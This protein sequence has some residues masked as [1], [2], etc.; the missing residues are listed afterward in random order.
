MKVNISNQPTKFDL[1][2]QEVLKGSKVEVQ[3]DVPSDSAKIKTDRRQAL[4]RVFAE[5]NISLSF[6]RDEKTNQVVIK[7]VDANSGKTIRQTPTD[8]SLKLTALYSKIQG[9]FLDGNF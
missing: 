4:K 3:R 8:V 2:A 7:M 5:H 9:Q 6:N 1:Q